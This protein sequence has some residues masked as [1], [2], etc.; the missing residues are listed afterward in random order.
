MIGQDLTMGKHRHIEL[1]EAQRIELEQLL[2]SGNAPAR[3]NTR[4][5]ILLQSD[6]S[7]GEQRI[8][9]EVAAAVM[10]NQSTVVSIRQRFLE[11]G[12]QRALYDKGWPR[13]SKF[14][15]EVEAQLTVLACSAPPEGAARWSLRLLAK[16]MIELGYVEYIS[17][18]T[19]GELLKKRAPA[20]AGEVL[21]YREALS[22]VRGQDG[23][24]AG[25][26]PMT[27]RQSVP[28]HLSGRDK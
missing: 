8:D 19:V 25:C 26:L 24:C 1:T 9:K 14:T 18:A 3:T 20:V 28:S 12:L 6:R 17:H 7:Q 15:G 5:R 16:R 21:M 4:A 11:G 23:G 13:T 10:C 2:R 27:L 22:D